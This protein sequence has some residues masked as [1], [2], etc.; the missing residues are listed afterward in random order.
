MNFD[1]VKNTDVVESERVKQI[2][3]D[4][5]IK[6][7]H[8]NERF[9]GSI[10]IE[11]KDWNIGLIVGGSGTGK[12][13]IAKEIFKEA[14]ISGYE[15]NDASVLDNVSETATVN[16]I[17][18]AFTSVGFSSPPCWLKPYS[19]LSTGEK[20]RVDLARSILSDRELVVFDEFTSVVDREVAKTCSVAI[21][22]SIRR[23][24]NKFVAISCHSDIIEYLSP[25]W[26]YDTDQKRFFGLRECTPSLNTSSTYTKLTD[27]ISKKSGAYLGSITI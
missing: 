3:S 15:Y 2:M 17:E 10:D 1:I 24:G 16:E 8:A 25:D 21:Q 19:V 13:T 27:L 6:V 9:T 22:K 12:S 18:R 4:F 14:Y 26:I 23:K 5:D 20:M 7:E 11:D